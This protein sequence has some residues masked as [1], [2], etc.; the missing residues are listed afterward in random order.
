MLTVY[1]YLNI[2]RICMVRRQSVPETQK[3]DLLASSQRL[4]CTHSFFLSSHR[5]SF[6]SAL[7]SILRVRYPEELN[8]RVRIMVLR[9]C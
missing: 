8:D 4:E 9:S 3:G 5:S 6:F 1:I 2:H 7:N